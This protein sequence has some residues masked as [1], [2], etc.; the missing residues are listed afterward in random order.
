MG[1]R[2]HQEETRHLPTPGTRLRLREPLGREV[3]AA[4]RAE[5][6]R[7]AGMEAAR[8]HRTLRKATARTFDS[9]PLLTKRL[10]VSLCTQRIKGE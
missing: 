3:P 1:A 4:G 10:S 5:D 8:G 9:F 6:H 2:C 7:D